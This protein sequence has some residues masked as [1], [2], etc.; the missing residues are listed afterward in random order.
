M[1]A[2]TAHGL[3]GLVVVPT[4]HL[5][6]NKSEQTRAS[7][8]CGSEKLWQYNWLE[9]RF[10]Q[11]TISQKQEI[12]HQSHMEKS[13]YTINTTQTRLQTRLKSCWRH[14]RSLRYWEPLT[15]APVGHSVHN[16]TSSSSPSSIGT[17]FCSTNVSHNKLVTTNPHHNNNNNNKRNL[18]GFIILQTNIVTYVPPLN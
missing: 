6:W 1:V 18:Y 8:V 12:N 15:C 9:L 13:D 10:S 16:I 7:K 2:L 3:C 5:H 14:T 17:Y 4:A 11:I